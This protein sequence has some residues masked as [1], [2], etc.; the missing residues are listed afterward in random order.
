[1]DTIKATDDVLDA[2][3]ERFFLEGDPRTMRLKAR[4]LILAKV[5]EIATPELYTAWSR[6]LVAMVTLERWL[7]FRPV[8]WTEE[9]VAF[10]FNLLKVLSSSD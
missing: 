2:L 5:A 3:T 8:E 7:E 9:G 6:D 1:L 4:S 10:M